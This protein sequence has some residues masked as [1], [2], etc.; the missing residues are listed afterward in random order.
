[1]VDKSK[2]QKKKVSIVYMVAGMSSRFGGKIKQF[3][4]VGPNGETLM[5][6]SMQQA[7]KA[8]FNEIIFIVGE[9]TEIP[10]KEKFNAGYMNTPIYYANQTFDPALRDKPWGTVDALISAKGVI[11]SPFVVCNGDDLYGE[12][13]FKLAH[14]FLEK[15]T[16]E[17]EC[18]TLGYEFGRVIPKTGK[19][20]RAKYIIDT[21]GNVT[22]LVEILGIDRSNMDEYGVNEKSLV[23]MNL[24]G[25]KEET[26]ELLEKKL[27]EFK[28]SHKEDRKS[29]CYLPT[30]INSLVQEKKIILKLL[31]TK[32]KWLG[33]TNPGDEEMV[34]KALER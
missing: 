12:K 21:K 14:D 27:F 26:L 18:V 3:E 31:P 15:S 10:F 24:F 8:G 5:E 4:K 19:T 25:L 1:M 30:E 16:S 34:R 13:S 20:N 2:A 7:I 33:I 32:D 17:K 29:E 6:V 22:G 23:S 28:E 9:K 11:T